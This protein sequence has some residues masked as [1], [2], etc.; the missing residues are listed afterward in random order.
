MPFSPEKMCRFPLATHWDEK[1]NIEKKKSYFIILSTHNK[2]QFYRFI[3]NNNF[4]DS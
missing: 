1:K 3:I 4:I 2:Q